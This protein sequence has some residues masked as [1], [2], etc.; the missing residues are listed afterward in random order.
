MRLSKDPAVC[1]AG[2]QGTKDWGRLFNFDLR[3]HDGHHVIRG[4]ERS[5]S[6]A[7][8][9]KQV[10]LENMKTMFLALLFPAN[11]LNG[12]FRLDRC[13]GFRREHERTKRGT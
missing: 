7:R 9:R 13:L 8:T 10:T 12:H 5:A 3:R 1:T 2:S 4:A 11:P 6:A